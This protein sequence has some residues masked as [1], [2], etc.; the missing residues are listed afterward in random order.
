MNPALTIAAGVA[1]AIVAA[2]K[3]NTPIAGGRSSLIPHR[4]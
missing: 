3:V 1:V 2:P 4:G